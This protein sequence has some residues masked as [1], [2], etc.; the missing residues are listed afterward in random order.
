LQHRKVVLQCN[1]LW[2]SSP[3]ADLQT[4]KEEKFN[5]SRLVPQFRP[6]I[7]CYK[8]DTNERLGAIFERHVGFMSWVSHIQDCYFG[9]KSI[10]S[11]T[12]EDDGGDPPV[13]PNAY[14]NPFAQITMTVPPPPVDDP[15]RGPQSSRHHPWSAGGN[16]PVQFDWVKL[17]TSLQWGAFQ[18]LVGVLRDRGDDVLVVLGPFNEHM[19]APESQA[20]Y[21]KL[22]DGIAAWLAQNH[23]P[24][25]VPEIL[26]S[27][28]Y[29][30]ASHP[31]TDGYAL[32][33]KQLY[34]NETFR[35]WAGN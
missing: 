35:R 22:H 28:L 21:H 27:D 11:W 6:R 34:Q 16:G 17:D 19:I 13:R 25:V 32:L 14:K 33:A 9:Q 10:L 31:L 8:A 12:L 7:P 20:G 2:M 24:H 1:V 23:I 30:D 29:A 18:R 5:H 26:P 4:Q 15:Q 3:K